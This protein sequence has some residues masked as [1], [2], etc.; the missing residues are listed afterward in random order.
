M[1]PVSPS[2]RTSGI[3]PFRVATTGTPHAIASSVAIENDST[4][5]SEGTTAMSLA[6]QNSGI[7]WRVPRNVTTSS[8]CKSPRELN[9]RRPLRAVAGDLDTQR[10]I[11]ELGNRSQEMID[12]LSRHEACSRT[13]SQRPRGAV[14][15]RC[16]GHEVLVVDAVVDPADAAGVGVPPDLVDHEVGHADVDRPEPR[17]RGALEMIP[18]PAH[19]RELPG[20]EQ[21]A[22]LDADDPTAVATGP[23]R[24]SEVA[25]VD[26][27]R[28]V[29]PDRG[30]DA[31]K[32]PRVSERSATP[33]QADGDVRDTVALETFDE[34]SAF[35]DEDHRRLDIPAAPLARDHRLHRFGAA[36]VAVPE[37]E[38]ELQALSPSP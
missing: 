13:G 34:L 10:H 29:R 33:R 20:C 4:N 9:E 31:G 19:A 1:L 21:P 15:V 2:A 22:V 14:L 27:Q 8:I 18:Q 35:R 5:V 32:P 12:A 24:R 3:P 36:E 30:H 26:E 11:A 16:C 23:E 37:H 6:R 7:A 17:A 28:A 25:A 38:C